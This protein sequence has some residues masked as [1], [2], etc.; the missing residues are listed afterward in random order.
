MDW[1]FLKK[2]TGKKREIVTRNGFGAEGCARK[3]A[4]TD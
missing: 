1:I 3:E 2:T 4:P